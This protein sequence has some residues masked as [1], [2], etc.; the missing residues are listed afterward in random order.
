[1]KVSKE[2]LK[3]QLFKK[4]LERLYNDYPDLIWTDSL[5]TSIDKELSKEIEGICLY[6]EDKGLIVKSA[7]RWRIT[8]LGID[9]LEQRDLLKPEPGKP[10][11]WVLGGEEGKPVPKTRE[12]MLKERYGEDYKEEKGREEAKRKEGERKGKSHNPL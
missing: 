5:A 6:L 12:E 2:F 3:I 9:L 4:I 7:D 1:M 8:A 10:D 11:F